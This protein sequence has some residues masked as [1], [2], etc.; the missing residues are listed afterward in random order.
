MAI[1]SVWLGAL[2]VFSVAGALLDAFKR[3]LPNLLCLAML[4]AGLVL[5]FLSGGLTAL[6]LHFAHA[7]LALVIGYLLFMGGIFGGGDGKFYAATA[8]FFPITQMLGLIV[9]IT[10]AGLVLAII[11]FGLKRINRSL[12]EKKGDF[13]KL[14][15][16][17]AIAVGALAQAAMTAL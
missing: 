17:V 16:G 9:G 5:A 4:V 10:M 3:K 13:A 6:G 11:W 8:A 1:A 7:A 2:G 14:P 15:Y 12:R